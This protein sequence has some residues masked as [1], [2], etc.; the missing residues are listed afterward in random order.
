[1]KKGRAG[2]AAA[3]VLLGL[4]ALTQGGC[5]MKT[6]TVCE[7]ML[8]YMSERYEDS[9][10]R[11]VQYG[12]YPGAP[13]SQYYMSS[14]KLGDATVKVEVRDHGTEQ[15]RYL[16]DYMGV[17]YAAELEETIKEMLTECFEVPEEDVVVLMEPASRGVSDHW[18]PETTFKQYCA[19]PAAGIRFRAVMRSE[20]NFRDLG[21]RKT[22]EHW[23]EDDLFMARL[24]CTGWLYFVPKD[25]PLEGLDETSFF[26][27][28][29]KFHY[30]DARLFFNMRTAGDVEEFTWD[31][32]GFGP[33]AFEYQ[34]M[35]EAELDRIAEEE[36]QVTA[37]MD[38]D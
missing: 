34:R 10:F 9:F 15:E 16:D 27:N 37:S 38:N 8:A 32:A 30:Y 24:C 26:E 31:T 17:V 28:I 14:E 1:M 19:D 20:E 13:V 36:N 3:A 2:K 23:L 4:L 6:Q 22:L 35:L 25:T 12:G 33:E 18:T 7:R 29:L 21:T 5:E 11:P